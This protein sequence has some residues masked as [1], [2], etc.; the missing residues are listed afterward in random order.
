MRRG[1]NTRDMRPRCIVC[2][3]GS[4]NRITPGGSSTPALM[5]SRMSLRV[6]ENVCQFTSASWTSACRDSAQKS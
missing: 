4:S 2:V 3:G 6:F 1:V 5:M